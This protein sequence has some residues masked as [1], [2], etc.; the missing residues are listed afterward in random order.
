VTHVRGPVD[1]VTL[2]G[3][4]V[5][6]AIP[7]AVAEGGNTTVSFEVLSYAGV[8][9]ISVIVDPDHGPALD[10]LIGRLRNELESIMALP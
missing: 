7:V 10:D 2:G 5:N 1:P 9:T 6:T 4:R 3:H 8:L